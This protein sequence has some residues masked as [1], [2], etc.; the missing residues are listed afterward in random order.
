V[1]EI[2]L[3]GTG[4]A[5]WVSLARHRQS[6]GGISTDCHQVARQQRPLPT[7]W[8]DGSALYKPRASEP[9]TDVH[10]VRN[11]AP[12]GSVVIGV[13]RVLYLMCGVAFMSISKL[14][15]HQVL[16]DVL[17]IVKGGWV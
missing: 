5:D 3:G 12:G 10:I 16:I 11:L 14:A 9:A 2:K 6:A 4:P 7:R 1:V 8:H 15:Q 17:S 13:P